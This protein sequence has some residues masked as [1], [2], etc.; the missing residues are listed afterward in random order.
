[1]HRGTIYVPVSTVG[2]ATIT[3]AKSSG[4]QFGGFFLNGSAGGTTITILNSA[5]TIY[6]TSA[7][8]AAMITLN[9]A[10][11]VSLTQLIATCSGTGY[12]TLFYAQ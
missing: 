3:V 6:A 7:G 10:A 11:P 1:M 12:Y 2:G 9:L 8:A 5:T 4:K